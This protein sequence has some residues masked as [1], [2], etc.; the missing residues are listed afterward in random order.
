[1]AVK[2]NTAGVCIQESCPSDS[3]HWEPIRDER[4]RLVG[5]AFTCMVCDGHWVEWHDDDK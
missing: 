5:N 4:N 3:L 2:G 1:M